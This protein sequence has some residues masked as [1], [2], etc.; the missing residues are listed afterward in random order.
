M[1]RRPP[2][3]TRTY[4]LFPYTTLFRSSVVVAPSAMVVRLRRPKEPF[5]TGTW[6]AAFIPSLFAALNIHR[7]CSRFQPVWYFRNVAPRLFD[8]LASPNASSY[9]LI[10]R[11]LLTMHS[12]PNL[13]GPILSP[14]Q[15]HPTNT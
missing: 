9:A 11:S 7:R 6:A 14:P 5:E 15:P 3:S 1:I 8:R 10:R 2:R 13:P 12:A 4:T